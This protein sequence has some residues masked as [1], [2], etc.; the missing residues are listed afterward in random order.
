MRSRKKQQ[1]SPPA[2]KSYQ[3]YMKSHTE[4]PDYEDWQLASNKKEAAQSFAK[5]MNQK[6]IADRGDGLWAWQDLIKHI[7]E[8]KENPEEEARRGNPN[9]W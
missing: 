1:P 9:R 7:R 5:R 2:L 4:A 6:I 8:I 3:I